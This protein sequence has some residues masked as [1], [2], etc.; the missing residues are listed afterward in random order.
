MSIVSF[1]G[2]FTLSYAVIDIVGVAL[3]DTI[4]FDKSYKNVRRCIKF[5]TIVMA[6][7]LCRVSCVRN[8]NLDRLV[9]LGILRLLVSMSYGSFRIEA[10]RRCVRRDAFLR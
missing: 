7:S 1:S 9:S 8:S 3:D 2:G 4:L 6:H 10:I 5:H